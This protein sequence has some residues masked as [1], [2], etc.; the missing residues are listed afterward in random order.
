M[1]YTDKHIDH[2]R[3]REIYKSSRE[4]VE[5]MDKD[6][7]AQDKL[8][9]MFETWKGTPKPKKIKS[10]TMFAPEGK[11]FE[12]LRWLTF[13]IVENKDTL[14]MA[15]AIK[16]LPFFE[17]TIDVTGVFAL[18]PH[19]KLYKLLETETEPKYFTYVGTDI[20]SI[21]NTQISNYA[22][23]ELAKLRGKPR[24][25]SNKR[26]NSKR[27]TGSRKNYTA[28]KSRHSTKRAGKHKK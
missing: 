22:S 28:R 27:R 13:R 14:V 21:S 15:Y 9:S 4:L 23:N 25:G 11:Y 5:N 10:V 17:S 12:Y 2:M 7:E 18:E 16:I 24:N 1:S 3:I 26:N 8:I 6:E 19:T 20:V